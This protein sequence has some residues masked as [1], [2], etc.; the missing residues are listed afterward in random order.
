MDEVVVVVACGEDGVGAV[1][2]EG[3][4]R[5]ISPLILSL[6]LLS[7]FKTLYRLSGSC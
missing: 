3:E 6:L 5:F 1:E 4:D 2:D 7:L